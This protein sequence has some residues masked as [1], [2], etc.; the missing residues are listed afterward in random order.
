MKKILLSLGVCNALV[1][2]ATN[3]E[4]AKELELLKQEI[5]QIK[6]EQ[7]ATNESILNEL[8]ALNYKDVQEYESFSAM[9]GAASKVYFSQDGLSI[10]GYGEYKY[11]KYNDFKNYSSDTANETRNKGEFNIVRFVPYIG[12]KF[13]D[14]IIM[15]TEIEF[16]DGGARS[17]NT[18]N[19][20]YAIVEFSYL[21]F[22]LDPSFNIRVGH[23]LTPMGLTNLNHEPTSFLTADRPVVETLIIPS[24][25]HT[26][27][28]LAHGTIDNFEYYAG[29]VT[30]PDA[31]SFTEGTFIQQGRLGARQFTD[32]FSFVT[33]LS[34]DLSSGVNIGGSFLY[35]TSGIAE[36]T[37]PGTTTGHTG[38]ADVTITMAEIHASYKKNGFDIQALASYGALGGDYEQLPNT[39]ISNRVNG[40]YITLGYDIF[41]LFKLPGEFYLVGEIERLDMDASSK[42]QYVDNN[43][44]FEYTGG[45]AYYPDPRVVLKTNYKVRDYGVDAKLAD[46]NSFALSLGFIF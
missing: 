13:N 24:T 29:V 27:G 26:N 22:L 41:N 40:Q 32:D 20:K 11:T 19:Y 36:E 4:L 44:F 2:G 30:S 46:E 15:N 14:Y 3:E 37:K 43:R 8:S 5:K 35:G 10:G 31:G 28:V 38:D 9:G 42:T 39:G 6:S 7:S 16:E 12:Y 1:Y 21:D 33:R 17:D 45:F 23:I 25:W 18:K 34:Y